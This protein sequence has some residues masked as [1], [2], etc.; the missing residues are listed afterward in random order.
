MLKTRG[1]YIPKG[2]FLGVLWRFC[3][4]GLRNTDQKGTRSEGLGGDCYRD[5]VLVK[6]F[7]LTLSP[8]LGYLNPLP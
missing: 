7:P 2:S 4:R 6:G 5:H 3:G 8:L 1:D